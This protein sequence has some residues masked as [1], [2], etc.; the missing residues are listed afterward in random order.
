MT[1][2]KPFLDLFLAVWS[3]VNKDDGTTD[4]RYWE[5]QR[6]LTKALEELGKQILIDYA[7]SV[8]EEQGS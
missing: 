5:I 7:K 8:A 6:A 1:N 4:T 2:S 3:T